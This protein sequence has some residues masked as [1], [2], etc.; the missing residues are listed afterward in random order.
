VDVNKWKNLAVA[1]LMTTTILMANIIQLNTLLAEGES[2]N[3]FYYALLTL[4]LVTIIFQSLNTI[5]HLFTSTL[6]IIIWNKIEKNECKNQLQAPV[7]ALKCYERI[8]N[9]KL[10]QSGPPRYSWII[11]DSGF[12]HPNSNPPS[13]VI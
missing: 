13:N 7:L 12:K 8:H 10:Q 9:K 4:V 3:K 6:W 1:C 5:L 2:N 11:V